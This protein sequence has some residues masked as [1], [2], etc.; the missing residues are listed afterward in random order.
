MVGNFGVVQILHREV[1]VAFDADFGQV[2]D[3]GVAAMFVHHFRLLFCQCKADA[4]LVFALG[5]GGF[6]SDVVAEINHNRETGQLGEVGLADFGGRNVA[7]C[8]GDFR[9]HFALGEREITGFNRH[10]G[11]NPLGA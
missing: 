8:A 2:D 6:V 1:G 9:R 10:D 7:E 3:L 4:P 11:F 5:F